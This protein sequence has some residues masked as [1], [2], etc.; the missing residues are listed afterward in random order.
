MKKMFLVIGL[1]SSFKA[2]ATT[3]TTCVDFTG[4]YL[5]PTDGASSPGETDYYVIQQNQCI[6]WTVYAIYG[7]RPS[8]SEDFVFGVDSGGGILSL[9]GNTVVIQTTSDEEVDFNSSTHGDCNTKQEVVSLDENRNLV[10][11]SQNIYYCDDGYVGPA[12][13]VDPRQAQVIKRK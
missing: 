12:T 8:S 1:L 6:G 2:F 7:G 9:E 5:I 4:T 11:T 3:P 13:Q 10:Y